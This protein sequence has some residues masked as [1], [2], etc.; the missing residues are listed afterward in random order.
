LLMPQA[1]QFKLSPPHTEQA[2][3]SF[4]HKPCFIRNIT[5]IP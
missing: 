3:I 4:R 5:C 1:Q 2:L